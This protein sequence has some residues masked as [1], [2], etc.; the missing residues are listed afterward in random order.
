MWFTAAINE[1]FEMP[2]IPEPTARK[3]VTLP[4]CMWKAIA[5]YRFQNRIPAEA[6]A[7][8]QLIQRGLDLPRYL[9]VSRATIEI[10]TGRVKHHPGPFSATSGPFDL[11]DALASELLKVE[12]SLSADRAAEYAKHIYQ[13]AAEQA[14]ADADRTRALLNVDWRRF[15]GVSPV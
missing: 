5:E 10:L 15:H 9:E 12:P 8:R 4:E 3:S 2:V 13:K 1:L 11:M 6:E 14:G 7:I